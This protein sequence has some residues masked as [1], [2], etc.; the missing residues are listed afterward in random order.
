MLDSKIL[1]KLFFGL[2]R[3][4]DKKMCF[5]PNPF[6]K[7]E[8]FCLIW[9]KIFWNRVIFYFVEILSEQNSLIIVT[10]KKI[11]KMRNYV[12]KVEQLLPNSFLALFPVVCYLF[13]FIFHFL[14]TVLIIAIALLMS[15]Y[16]SKKL[17]I[18]LLY[19]SR[20]SFGIHE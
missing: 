1:W 4:W 9:E 8:N 13:F 6:S 5:I 14:W 18:S 7:W 3:Q 19:I 17:F 16:L 10:S 11:L 2:V 15:S 12:L 20:K